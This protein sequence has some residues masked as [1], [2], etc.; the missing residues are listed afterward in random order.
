MSELIREPSLLING[1]W[2][3]ST[4]AEC[5]VEDPAT[6]QVTGVC[7]QASTSGV[8]FAVD[9][10]R[11]AFRLWARTTVAERAAFL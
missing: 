9:A 10:A 7:A 6:E 11:S 2:V 3:P 1:K 8:D 5:E 4:G